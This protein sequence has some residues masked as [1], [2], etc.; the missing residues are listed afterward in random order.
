MN[1]MSEATSGPVT[2]LLQDCREGSDDAVAALLEIV[3]SELRR[4][5]VR[6]MRNERPEHTLQPTALVHEAFFR[7]FNGEDVPFENS[8]QFFAASVRNMRRVLTD[9]A[10]KTLAA[11]RTAA[12]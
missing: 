6:V 1:P 7:L 12:S 11:K 3:Y 8:Q 9:H 2:L 4:I 5:A 10:R